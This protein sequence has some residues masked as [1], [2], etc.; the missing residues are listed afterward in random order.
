MKPSE[1]L[2]DLGKPIAFYPMIAKKIGINPCLLLCQLLYWTGKQKDEGGWVYKTTE[3]WEQETCLTYEEQLSARKYLKRLGLLLEKHK[4]LEHKLFYK[5]NSE[6]LDRLLSGELDLQ[7]AN[8]R[9]WENPTREMGIPKPDEIGKTQLAIEHRVPESNSTPPNG[10]FS[11][12]SKSACE[13]GKKFPPPK[14]KLPP[15]PNHKHFVDWWSRAFENKFGAPYDFLSAQDGANVK[16]LLSI[17]GMT[18]D[19]LKSIVIN[20]WNG[21]GAFHCK[22]MASIQY[23]RSHINEIRA[24]QAAQPSWNYRQGSV[25]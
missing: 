17:N 16:H 13:N 18:L 14:N 2:M 10:D 7:N 6:A 24:E 1:L 4:K 19:K 3:E 15:N 23:L 25:I 12:G 11:G 9:D 20:C 5:L 22:N 21:V 8:S